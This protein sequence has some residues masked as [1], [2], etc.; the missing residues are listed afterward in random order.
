MSSFKKANIIGKATVSAVGSVGCSLGGILLGQAMIPVPFFGALVGGIF[1][2]YF[3]AKGT[4]KF[5]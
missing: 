1:G 5:N 2:G 4:N 3:G